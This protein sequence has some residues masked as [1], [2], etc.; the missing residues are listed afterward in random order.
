MSKGAY[1][2]V[3]VLGKNKRIEIGKLGKIQFLKGYY[4]Y[5]GSALNSL[6]KRIERHKRKEK[7]LHWHIDHFLKHAKII[8]TIKIETDKKVECTISKNI[9]KIADDTISGFGCSDCKCS[10]HLY[11]SKK[12][13][14]KLIKCTLKK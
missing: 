1:C 3:M 5:V 13:P 12:N 7:R 9:A 2:L 8:D 10:S 11:Y 6:E 4:C 14:G